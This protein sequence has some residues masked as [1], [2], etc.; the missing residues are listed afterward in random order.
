VHIHLKIHR[1]VLWWFYV[2]VLCGVIALVNILTRDLTRLQEH[3]I[4]II[5]VLHW[6][7]G[8]FVCWAFDGVRIHEP[9]APTERHE[10]TPPEPGRGWHPG[11]DFVLP[12]G[13]KSLLPPK[14]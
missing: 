11:S 12:G 10:I 4:L 6:V 7:L 1:W 2:G 9:P 5:G 13:R 8:G 3:V 14:Y